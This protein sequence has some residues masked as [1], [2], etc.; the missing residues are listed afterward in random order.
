MKKYKIFVDGIQIGREVHEDGKVYHFH[1]VGKKDRDRKE[2]PF[3]EP[4]DSKEEVK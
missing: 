2:G 1:I 3:P 4:Y